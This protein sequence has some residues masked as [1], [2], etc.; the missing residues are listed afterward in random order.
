MKNYLIGLLSILILIL[1]YFITLSNKSIFTYF[2]LKKNLENETMKLESLKKERYLLQNNVK[3]LKEKDLDL[4]Y[5]DEIAREKH[6]L[7]KPDEYIIYN[8]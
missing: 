1:I 2:E 5:L 8:D 7:S 6:N 4:D 3:K